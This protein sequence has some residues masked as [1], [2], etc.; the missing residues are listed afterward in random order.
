VG[1]LKSLKKERPIGEKRLRPEYA[2]IVGLH[3]LEKEILRMKGSLDSEG[4]D[5]PKNFRLIDIRNKGS[6]GEG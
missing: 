3:Y 1:G 6:H 5:R 4:H 2:R